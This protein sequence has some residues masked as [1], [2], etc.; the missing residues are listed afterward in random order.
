MIIQTQSLS[1]RDG[2]RRPGTKI[3]II[4]EWQET[5]HCGGVSHRVELLNFLWRTAKGRT[6]QQMG[7]SLKGPFVGRKRGE[8]DG[9]NTHLPPK[10]RPNFWRAA[11]GMFSDTPCEEEEGW[12]MVRLASR[13]IAARRAGYFQKRWYFDWRFPAGV[14]ARVISNS[15]PDLRCRRCFDPGRHRDNK[16]H[17]L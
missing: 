1:A 16:P 6:I 14:R 9:L 10:L 5:A 12:R 13:S 4:P 15:Q 17:R 8:H 7:S 2:N 11:L 3:G